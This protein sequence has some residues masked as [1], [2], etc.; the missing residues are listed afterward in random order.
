MPRVSTIPPPLTSQGNGYRYAGLEYYGE[1][2]CG[3]S[4][5]GPQIDESNCVDPCT[6]NQTQACGGT[7]IISVYMD[8]T[9]PAVVN[10]TIADY[11]SLGC[12]SEGTNGRALEW[13]QNQLSTTNMTIEE[14]LFA[15]KDGGYSFGGVEFAT[16]CFCGVVLGMWFS[17]G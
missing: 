9:F 16:Q 17:L 11:Q 12:Y 2:F 5:N 6:G 4:V 7:D 8:P 3:A 15:C 14:C 13:Q 1:C 10:T